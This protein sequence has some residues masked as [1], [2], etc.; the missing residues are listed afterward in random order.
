MKEHSSVDLKPRGAP[1]FALDAE[2]GDLV[3][4]V[5]GGFRQNH[6]GGNS[7]IGDSVIVGMD[8]YTQLIFAI[9]KGPS[10][11]TITAPDQG[12]PKGTSVTIKGRITD[13]SPGT[14]DSE[15]ALRFSNGVPVMA[16]EIMS[17][18][19]LY[20]YKQFP[21]PTNTIVVP[22]KIEIV[23][24]DYQ[25]AWIGTATTAMMVILHFY[26]YP[27]WRDNIK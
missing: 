5:N 9:G 4:R 17:D 24:P 27:Q 26:G 16:D 2:T 3:W 23:D 12:I 13:E 14:K 11:A 7:I 25:Y 1:Y 18:W 10:V 6:W 20:V 8:S 21:M 15:I 19:M 22:V